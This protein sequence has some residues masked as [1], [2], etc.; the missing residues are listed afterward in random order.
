MIK[1]SLWILK[2]TA[3]SAVFLLYELGWH[4]F[5]NM[6]WKPALDIFKKIATFAFPKKFFT[7]QITEAQSQLSSYK[8]DFVLDPTKC[9]EDLMAP[10]EEKLC[11]LPHLPQLAIKIAACYFRLGEVDLAMKWLLS[12]PV[13][14]KKYSNF[15]SKPEEDFAKLS[16]KFVTRKSKQMLVFEIFYFM[17]YMPK[18]PDEILRLILDDVQKY[19]QELDFSTKH[20][21]FYLQKNV[22]R[23]EAL[24]VEYFSAILIEVVGNS[25]LGE[26]E[27]TSSIYEDNKAYLNM[28]PDD[29]IYMIPHIEYWV[30]RALVADEKE[31]EARAVLKSAIKRK[32]VEFNIVNKIK[33]VMNDVD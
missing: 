11:I 25:L 16:Q 13:I 6:K 9:Q 31:K 7:S 5:L 24:I 20:L 14:H 26:I 23:N 2:K 12:A 15:K 18:L 17:R 28:I 10:E 29:Y 27:L 30:G 8:I 32:K 22:P 21:N 3:Q 4:H 1:N 33:K 19:K